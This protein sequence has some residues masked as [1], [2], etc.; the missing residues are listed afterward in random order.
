MAI[1]PEGA[2]P[3]GGSKPDHQG[4]SLV[5]RRNLLKGV[6][7]A[8]GIAAVGGGAYFVTQS[9]ESSKVLPQVDGKVA[10]QQSGVGAN[11]G[12][13]DAASPSSSTTSDEVF[14]KLPPSTET[15][16]QPEPRFNF[17]SN[18][19]EKD[20][21]LVQAGASLAREFFFK[22]MGIYVK[23]T[24]NYTVSSD[25]SG[26]DGV[27]MGNSV[28]LNMG[29]GLANLPDH[30]KIKG[31]VHES[32][33]SLQ[34]AMTRKSVGRGT[35]S[36][37]VGDYLL[38]EG[39]A[40]YLAW[41]ALVDKGYITH[42]EFRARN[43][44]MARRIQLPHISQV[45]N[46]VKGNSYALGALAIDYLCADKGAKAMGDYLR[47]VYETPWQEAFQKTFSRPVEDFHAGFE[48]WRKSNNV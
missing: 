41:M 7:G 33:H 40:E 19:S 34:E 47:N 22:K 29:R 38:A 3:H 25:P 27:A 31:V 16:P 18:V 1:F 46:L 37:Q 36:Q 2:L 24:M 21:A 44:E 14:S 26:Q 4:G 6:G 8:L 5:S 39:G 28:T 23:G 35:A 20:R 13:L 45:N 43:L 10:G 48:G 15:S 30:E 42:D 32:A 12:A 17:A 9:G 11:S